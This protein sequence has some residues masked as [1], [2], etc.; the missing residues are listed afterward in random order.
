MAESPIDVLDTVRKKMGYRAIDPYKIADAPPLRDDGVFSDE[1]WETPAPEVPASPLV[2]PSVTTIGPTLEQPAPAPAQYQATLLVLDQNASYRGHAVE[3][4]G[5]D[6]NAIATIVLRAA[7]RQ[8][9]NLLNE[10]TPARRK[11]AVSVDRA[12]LP[13]VP[14]APSK[15]RG[16]P[17]GSKDSKPRKR[18]A[19]PAESNAGAVDANATP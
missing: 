7:K 19:K 3:L 9:D 6:V 11:A 17:E 1:A 13:S 12:T 14:A 5:Q 2:P 8:T 4:D 18:R 16:R 15:K 10:L